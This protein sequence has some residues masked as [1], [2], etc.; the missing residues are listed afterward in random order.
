MTFPLLG[1]LFL[2]LFPSFLVCPMGVRLLLVLNDLE[3]LN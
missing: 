2:V 3:S 1:S